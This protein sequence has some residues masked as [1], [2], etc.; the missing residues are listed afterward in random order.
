MK[1]MIQGLDSGG[2]WD[3][4]LVGDDMG[5]NTFGTEL[6]ALAAIPE[7]IELWSDND[8]PPTEA[9]FRVVERPTT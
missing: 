2:Q 1:Y 6:E 5:A 8:V 7:L 4:S 9:D 3:E